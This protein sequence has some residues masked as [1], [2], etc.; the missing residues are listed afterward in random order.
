MNFGL[1]VKKR[2]KNQF[3]GGGGDFECRLP[4]HGSKS[5]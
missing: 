4:N 3:L 2:E 1:E 5:G